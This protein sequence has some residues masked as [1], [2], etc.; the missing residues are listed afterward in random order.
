[1]SA[2]SSTEAASRIRAVVV[3]GPT[4]SGKSALGLALAQ[5]LGGVIINADSQQRYRE[6]PI[7]TARPSEAEMARA[8]H[9]LFADL[10]PDETGSA[11]E[12]AMKA[13]NAVRN[14]EGVPILVGGT[15]LYLR[16]L[17][18]G[19]AD[20]PKVPVEVRKRVQD[21]MREIG[22][23]AFHAALVAR[24]PG[25]ARLKPGDTQRNIRAAEVLEATGVPLSQW[26]ARAAAAPL[27]A[28]YFTVLLAPARVDLH[29][30]CDA[31]FLA[32][33][34]RGAPDEVKALVAAGVASDAPIMRVLGAAPLAAHLAG[35][36]SRDEAIS[37]AQASTRQYAKRQDTWFRNQVH[38]DLRFAQPY[39]SELLPK[40]IAAVRRFLAGD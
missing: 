3:A 25:S 29:A 13:A 33:M 32:M 31:R 8:P 36:L 2:T 39:A 6:L 24:D 10:G 17:M 30:N 11:A 38:A 22:N 20:V 15:G 1:M 9:C 7:L 14:V 34:E 21:R 26:Q 18:N 4:A 5:E 16:A 23:E 37:R 12:W 28:Q 27:R 35:R 19:L 40:V